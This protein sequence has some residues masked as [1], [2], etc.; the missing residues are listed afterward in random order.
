MPER[1]TLTVAEREASGWIVRMKAHD[2]SERERQQFQRWLEADPAH[3]AAYAKLER[4]WGAVESLQHLKGR[5]AANDAAPPPRNWTIPA[6]AI[7]ACALLAISAGVWFARTPG[8]PAGEHYATAPAEVR[9]ITLADGTTV[10]LSG[11]GAATI[12][13]THTERRVEL[14]SGYALFDVA[15]DENRPFV[16]HTP[17]GDITV[18]GTSFV[19]RIANGEVRTTVLRGSVSGAAERSLFG[20][21]RGSVTAGVNEEIVLNDDGA[22]LVEIAAEAI[23]RRLAWRDN[24][25]AFD[26]ETL[27][28]AIAEVSQQTG[29]QFELA[30]PS[31]GAERVGGYVHADP[32]A[33]IELMSSSLNLEAHREGER[34]VVLARRP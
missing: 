7:A 17:E 31:L 23:P 1:R 12:A 13:V 25:L 22:A 4:T 3:R 10:T 11:A 21:S 20:A 24:M 14:T 9:T 26:G 8:A 27:N 29:W 19:V 2:V 32:E 16:V 5:A 18:L 28:E 6:I 30:D 33:F 34:H 15:H